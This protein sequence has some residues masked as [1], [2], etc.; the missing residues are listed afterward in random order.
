VYP[1]KR[2]RLLAV[3]R[4]LFLKHGYDGTSM[5]RL[6]AAAKVAPNTLYWYFADKDALLVEVLNDTLLQVMPKYAE[7]ASEPL[8]A[9]LL[10][11]VD[12]LDE[13]RQLVVTVHTREASSP[14]IAQWHAQFHAF[15]E[16]QFVAQIAAR[17]VDAER[18]RTL[19]RMTTFVLEGL[20]GHPCTADDRTRIVTALVQVLA[21][22][23]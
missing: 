22:V 1:K 12:V 8:E 4:R 6:A 9:Q 19:A 23:R 18:A 5:T 7:H 15:L 13:A 17:G 16:A 10:W 14:P 21:T 2:A 20:L 3:A 11:L